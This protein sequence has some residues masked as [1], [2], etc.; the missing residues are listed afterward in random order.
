MLVSDIPENLETIGD[1]GF[2]FERSNPASLKEKLERLVREPDL[3]KEYGKR[4]R[5]RVTSVH[6]WDKMAQDMQELH[7][8][9]LPADAS[10]GGDSSGL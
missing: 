4:A 3:M 8:F 9:V 10:E 6:R 5:A 1:A 2:S 7:L